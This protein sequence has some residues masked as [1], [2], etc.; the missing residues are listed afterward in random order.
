[1]KNLMGGIIVVDGYIYL[2]K[3]RSSEWYAINMETGKENLLTNEFGNGVIVYADGLFYC[4]NEKGEVAL[5]DITPE[6]FD[7]KGLF[8][9]P[10]GTKEHWAHPIIHNKRMYIRHGNALMVYDLTRKE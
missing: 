5:V 8:D 2:S 3:Y 9:I 6:S 4:Y 10:L 1:M 7:I